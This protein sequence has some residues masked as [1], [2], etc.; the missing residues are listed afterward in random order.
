MCNNYSKAKNITY[1]IEVQGQLEAGW[2]DWFDGMAM[3]IA[4]TLEG[5]AITTLR[6]DVSDQAALRGI[7]NKLWDLNLTLISVQ[8]IF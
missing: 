6:G 2:A 8:Q 1:R 3:D 7:L 4:T 5:D